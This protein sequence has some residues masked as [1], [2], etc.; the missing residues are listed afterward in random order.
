MVSQIKEK[1]PNKIVV[2]YTA[3]TTAPSVQ[4]YLHFAD[5][6]M[7]KGTSIEDWAELLTESVKKIANP[8]HVWKKMQTDLLKENVSTREIALL[9]DKFVKAIKKGKYESLKELCNDNNSVS[10]ILEQSIPLLIKVLGFIG[11]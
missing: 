9:E 6:V 8:V 4:K 7:A 2:S 5:N 1:Y 11:Q 3:D 10:K